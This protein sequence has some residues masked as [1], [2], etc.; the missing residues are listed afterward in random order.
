MKHKIELNNYIIDLVKELQR[1]YSGGDLED[2]ESCQ[3]LRE[4]KFLN[5]RIANEV[6]HLT[7]EQIS[8]HK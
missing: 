3:W 6:M 2:L 7:N 1:Y 8:R 5:K 4:V